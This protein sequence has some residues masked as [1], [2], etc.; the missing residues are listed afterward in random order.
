MPISR[1]PLEV[2]V[3]RFTAR[4]RFIPSPLPSS[5]AVRNLTAV[6]APVTASGH[7]A[8]RY[9]M[10]T[11]EETIAKTSVVAGSGLCFR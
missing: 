10:R 3:G 7:V 6:P 2:P 1:R 4:F 11:A 9:R 5:Q 8:L